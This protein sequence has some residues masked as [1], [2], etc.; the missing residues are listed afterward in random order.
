M[1]CLRYHSV[2]QRSAVSDRWRFA[3]PCCDSVSLYP[4][5]DGTYRCK[6]CD[7]TFANR[8][9]NKHDELG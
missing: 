5:Q 1:D 2:G 6:Q 8:Y 7:E 3:C 9:D 4:R